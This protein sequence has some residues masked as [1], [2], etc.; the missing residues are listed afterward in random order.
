MNTYDELRRFSGLNETIKEYTILL[1]RRILE[2]ERALAIINKKNLPGSLK[3][4]T[5]NGHAYFYLREKHDNK[6]KSRYI[7]SQ[8][9]DLVVMLANRQYI[10]RI[11]PKLKNELHNAEKYGLQTNP[12]MEDEFISKCDPVLLSLCDNLVLSP[13][14]SAELWQ[15]N[16]PPGVLDQWD[17]PDKLTLRGDMVRSKSEVFIADGLF[18]HGLKYVYEKPFMF[19]S[20]KLVHPDFTILHPQT[21]EEYCW[22]HFGKMDDSDYAEDNIKKISEYWKDGL[23][24]GKKL[25]CTFE[26]LKTPLTSAMVESV[27]NA[28]FSPTV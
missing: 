19:A 24:P 23:I 14:K 4:E 16:N 11:L 18:R 12:R 20:G 15:S 8:A 28:Y 2:L 21:Y 3:I 26:T 27:I 7:S 5:R 22:E 10:E 17:A 1:R 25:I 6:Y 13:E 9:D